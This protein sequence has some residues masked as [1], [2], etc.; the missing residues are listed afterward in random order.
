MKYALLAAMLFMT[1]CTSQPTTLDFFAARS[2]FATRRERETVIVYGV[3]FEDACAH[4][5]AVLMDLDCEL[6]EINSQLG[7]VSALPNPRGV[8]FARAEK[9]EFQ[10]DSCALRLVTVTVEERPA[11]KLA[12]RASFT[13]NGYGAE[14]AFETLLRRSIA[15]Q[16]S[17]SSDH[18]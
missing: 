6:V 8:G 4:V 11:G 18:E 3:D 12:I 15:Q 10:P 7:V 5:T 16:T 13:H 17:A 9:K 14:R 2:E 1:A